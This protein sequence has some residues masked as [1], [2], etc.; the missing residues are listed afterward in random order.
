MSRLRIATCKE[1]TCGARIVWCK[2]EEG[3]STPIDEEPNIEG[4]WSIDDSDPAKP[5]TAYHDPL[6]PKTRD[7]QLAMQLHM[8]HWATCTNR[9]RF[10]KAKVTKS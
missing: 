6:F 2:T 9:A 8:S 5:M 10:K 7:Q 4:R 3:R 1:P